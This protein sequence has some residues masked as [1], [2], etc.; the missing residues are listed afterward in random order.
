MTT[1]IVPGSLKAIAQQEG[2]PLAE[3]FLSADAIV[4]VDVSGSMSIRDVDN[5]GGPTS[6]YFGEPTLASGRSRYEAACDELAR[7][8]RELPGAIAVVQFSSGVGFCW[9]GRPT[10]EGMGTDLA[11]ALKFVQAADGTV[12]FF[13]ISDGYPDD[14]DRALSLA[15]Q[16][17]SAIHAIFI[18]PESDTAGAAFMRKLAKVAGGQSSVNKVPELAARVAGLLAGGKAA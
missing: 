10:Y 14:A 15:R 3:S 18:G 4:I 6:R 9:G 7:L 5:T 16:F 2:K 11:G 8:Q 1:A 12:E 17:D 13:V